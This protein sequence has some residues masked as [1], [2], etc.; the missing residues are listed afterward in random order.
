MASKAASVIEI[1]II[2]NGA[3][4]MARLRDD[5]ETTCG[6]PKIDRQLKRVCTRTDTRIGPVDWLART[7]PS[8]SRR[9]PCPPFRRQSEKNPSIGMFGPI[10]FDEAF[11]VEV[12]KPHAPQFVNG[13]A[14]ACAKADKT[15]AL[16]KRNKV[17]VLIH[18]LENLRPINVGHCGSLSLLPRLHGVVATHQPVL[19]MF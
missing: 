10:L 18:G 3:A 11:L 14:L 17:A 5:R 15:P 19:A 16:L 12:V 4:T 2:V 9:R 8:A 6:R 13:A 7:A 1:A